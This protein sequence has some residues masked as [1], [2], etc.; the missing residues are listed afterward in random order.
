[1]SRTTQDTHM[2]RSVYTTGLSPS[3]AS[4]SSDFAYLLT[5]TTR[6][7]QPPD[8]NVIGIWAISR[9]LVTTRKIS[10]DFYSSRYL[11]ISV[12]WVCFFPP[13]NSAEDIPA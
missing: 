2:L 8:N 5:V 12:P 6:V 11:D 9:S 4:L 3:M 13:M 7:L 10:F 1:V